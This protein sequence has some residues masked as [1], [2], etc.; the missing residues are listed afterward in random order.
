MHEENT[1]ITQDVQFLLDFAIA[2]HPKTGTSTIMRL[3]AS[4]PDIAMHTLE[5][6]SLRKGK[7]AEFIHRMYELPHSHQYKQGYKAPNEICS[8]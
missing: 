6:R 7:Q 2:G 5:I 4:Y 8:T 1:T 3:L